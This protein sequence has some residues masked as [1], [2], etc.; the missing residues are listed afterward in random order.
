MTTGDIIATIETFGDNNNILL[1]SELVKI[2][3]NLLLNND[4]IID[5]INVNNFSDISKINIKNDLYLNN[6]RTFKKTTSGKTIIEFKS[7]DTFTVPSDISRINILVVGGGGQSGYAASD[8]IRRQESSLPGGE[9]ATHGQAGTGRSAGGGAGRLIYFENYQVNE[10]EVFSITIGR[11]GGPERPYENG[12]SWR[13]YQDGYYANGRSTDFSSNSTTRKISAL[14]GGSGAAFDEDYIYVNAYSGGSGGGAWNL[15]NPGGTTETNDNINYFGNS[16]GSGAVNSFGYP[17]GGGGGG[18]SKRGQNAWESDDIYDYFMDLPT[19]TELQTFN[20][21]INR[22]PNG[23]SGGEG[24][25]IEEFKDYGDNGYFAQG[26]HTAWYPGAPGSIYVNGFYVKNRYG[27]AGVAIQDDIGSRYSEADGI[28]NTGAGG[29]SG[30]NGGSGVVIISYEYENILEYYYE[31]DISN[32]NFNEITTQFITSTYNLAITS[33][34]RYKINEII[35]NNGL[36]II[37]KLTAKKYIKTQFAY[38]ASYNGALKSGD[39]GI[40]ESGFIAQE[41]LDISNINYVVSYS[42]DKYG[43]KYND[44]FVYLLAAI[45]ELNQI[46]ENQENTMNL[47][48]NENNILKEKSVNIKNALNE[49]LIENN[50]TI[51]T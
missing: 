48:E 21:V 22:G 38:D 4:L 34:D 6:N 12:F 5:N 51:I 25:Y 44:L 33:D 15:G 47:I 36:E 39:K 28:P 18:A 32:G 40:I 7:N 9:F 41:L 27:G 49:L 19:V 50:E 17:G 26:G 3:D 31:L 2:S 11:G 46:F 14:G 29:S 23:H 37:N 45:K 1:N 20:S 13:G 16:G 43:V 24:K 8:A 30:G 35:I 42:N 10:G